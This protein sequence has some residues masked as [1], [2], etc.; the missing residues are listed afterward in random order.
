ML[1][2]YGEGFIVP[3]QPENLEDHRLSSVSDCLFITFAANFHVWRTSPQSVIWE[4]AK[5]WW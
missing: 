3:A 5:P 2:L 1:V 4:H